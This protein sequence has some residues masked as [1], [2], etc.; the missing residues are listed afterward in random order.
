M[1]DNHSHLP[2]S[3][4]EPLS[5]PRLPWIKGRPDVLEEQ[6]CDGTTVY[7]DALLL[8]FNKGTWSHLPG[9]LSPGKRHLHRSFGIIIISWPRLIPGGSKRHPWFSGGCME[10][11]GKQV[12]VGLTHS[13]PI[14][15][16]PSDPWTRPK[17]ISSVLECLFVAG[18]LAEWLHWLPDLWCECHYGRKG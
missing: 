12:R 7:A 1:M 3:T 5:T 18:V 14:H 17:V 8:S 2:N 15:S 10:V 16:D 13:R 11:Y 6:R 4:R 9:Q